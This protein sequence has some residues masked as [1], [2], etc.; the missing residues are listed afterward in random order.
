MR[1]FSS[2]L[3]FLGSIFS[4]HAGAQNPL[5][6]LTV[7]ELTR[8][9]IQVSWYSPER[10]CV[11]IAVQRSVDSNKNFRTIFSAQSPELANNGFV[12]NKPIIGK[13]YY[14]IFYVTEGGAY[15]FTRNIMIETQPA[16]FAETTL[17]SFEKAKD[18]TN[19]YVKKQLVFRL[20]KEEYAR[21][22]DSIFKTKDILHR[23]DANNVEWRPAPGLKKDVV[24]IYQ[25]DML[26]AEL[27]K[28]RYELFKDSIKEY[29]RDTLYAIDASR[30]QVHPFI[31]IPRG[32]VFIYRNDSLLQQMDLTMYRRFK[33]S[34]TTQ[35]KDTLFAK[36]NNRVDIHPFYPKYAW[37]PSQYIFTNSKGYLTIILPLANR[38]KYHIIFYEEDGT[39]LFRIRSVKET[40][41]IL[42]KTDFVHAGWF[43]FELF[44]D[45]KLKEKNKFFLTKD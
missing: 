30:V 1:P 12:D 14:R 20:T 23:V 22:R 21:F 6:D 33:D 7:K 29:T 24:R 10:N 32:S 41:L 31:P 4:I 34:V 27:D 43:M 11:Q 25:K 2:L 16:P 44:E 42:D 36:E 26:L 13:A 18:L 5:P 8:G 40:E 39:E 19:I 35:T 15:F 38:H 37:R 45:D 17:H 28:A 9:K 3:L